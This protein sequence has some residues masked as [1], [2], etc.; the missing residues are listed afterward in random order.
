MDIRRYSADDLSGVLQLCT[1]E[2]WPSLPEDPAR[3]HRVLTAPGVTTVVATPGDTVIGFAQLLSDGEIQAYLALIA[4]HPQHRRQGIGRAMLASALQLA[5][6]GRVDLLS[7]ASGGFHRSLP[8]LR[9]QGFRLYPGY[10]GP[11]RYRPGVSWKDG[12][13]VKEGR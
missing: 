13:E 11:D 12:R 8:H 7:D 5:G 3:A 9:L 1:A 6:G 4:V 2:G 10:T